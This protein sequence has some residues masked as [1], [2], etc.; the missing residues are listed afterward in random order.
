MNNFPK[1]LLRASNGIAL[2]LQDIIARLDVQN[3]IAA[4]YYD[5]ESRY[6]NQPA[7]ANLVPTR[8]I[9]DSLPALGDEEVTYREEVRTRERKKFLVEK[10]TLF[11]LG[12]YTLLTLGIYWSAKKSADSAAR[13][14]HLDQRAWVVPGIRKPDLLKDVAVLV[15]LELSN[16][17]KTAAE[18]C[19]IQFAVH[20][21]PRGQISDFIYTPHTGHPHYEVGVGVFPPNNPVESR[22]PVIDPRT[23]QPDERSLH[24]VGIVLSD[25]IRAALDGGT[26]WIGVHGRL[27]YD[28][29]FGISHWQTFCFDALGKFDLDEAHFKCAAYNQID[30][31]Q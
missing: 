29:V 31:N 16:T 26:Y 8:V 27:T 30:H 11:V 3:K 19:F 5:E 7:P 10:I 21:L 17:G 22:W 25:E 4:K 1:Q 20:L 14:L 9:V 2:K 24:P 23:K 13:A 12:I 15:P 18:K 28:D 6:R